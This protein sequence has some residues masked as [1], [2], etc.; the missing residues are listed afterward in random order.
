LAAESGRPAGANGIAL[1]P[2]NR[3]ADESGRR[4]EY[5]DVRFNRDARVAALTV[6]AADGAPPATVDQ[7]LALGA[8]WWPLQM[9]R[10]LDDAIL[11]LRTN[12]LEL[13]LWI[14]KATGN[15]EAVVA[16]D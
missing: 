1:T 3:T 16:A 6:R 15:P 14:F 5:V 2:L 13:G 7:V 8:S 12:E 4:Y 11:S 10:E 9:A